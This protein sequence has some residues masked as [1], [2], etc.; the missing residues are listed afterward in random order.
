MTNALFPAR[1]AVTAAILGGALA[2]ALVPAAA[3][4]ASARPK[5]AADLQAAVDRLVADGQPGVIALSRRNGKVTH[6]TAGVADK[7]TGQA[8]DPRLQVRVA[9]VTKTFTATVVLQL[10]AERRLSLNDTVDRWLPGVV[11]AN[12]NDGAKITIRQL[13]GQTSGLNDY[14]A[15]PRVMTDPRRTW[16]PRELVDIAQE[17]APRYAPGT[18]WNYSNTNYVLAGMV[19]EKVTRRSLGTELQRRIFH[20]LNLRHTSL[21]GAERTFPGPHVHG[22]WGAYG[23]VSTEVSPS[24][25]WASGGIIST[26]GD[27]ARFQRALVTGRLLPPRLQRELTTTRPVVDEWIEED[28]G[29]GVARRRFSCGPAWGH[30]G[31]FPGYRTWAYTSADGKRQAVITYNDNAAEMEADPRFRAHLNQA[32]DAALCG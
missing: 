5:P 12:G 3:P 31:G 13:L 10:A 11:R 27:V 7:A 4:A 25:A 24:S 29:L 21:P 8:M 14:T 16:K 18:S 32:I 15:D 23:D 6:A 28:Y 26:V 30:D 19:V 17:K 2:A 1:R 9:S 20:P 22:Y